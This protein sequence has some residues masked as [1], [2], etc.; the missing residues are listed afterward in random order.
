MTWATQD[1]KRW[2]DG[3][4]ELYNKLVF[5]VEA[6]TKVWGNSIAITDTSGNLIGTNTT[7]NL[8]TSCTCW[9]VV[10]RQ[11][12]N[13]TATGSTQPG[14][15]SGVACSVYA[16]VDQGMFWFPCCTG[17]DAVT[18]A[19][20]GQKMFAADNASVAGTN[21]SSSRPP[22]GTLMAIAGS[23]QLASGIPAGY[24]LI[25]IGPSAQAGPL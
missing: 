14:G 17:A 8:S 7:A 2:Q 4:P 25:A 9:G 10:S 13:T 11:V 12:D 22:V 19:N 21:G 23:T 5:P 3:T 24:V 18:N 20:I 6:N 16:D 1:L 15:G